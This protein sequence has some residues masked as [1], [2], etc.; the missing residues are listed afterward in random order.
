MTNSSKNPVPKTVTVRRQKV[1]KTAFNK[2]QFLPVSFVSI[3]TLS[4]HVNIKDPL[5]EL[6]PFFR[7][8][9]E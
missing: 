1:P 9:V 3:A 5:A 2:F 7:S 4:Q 8:K 6:R